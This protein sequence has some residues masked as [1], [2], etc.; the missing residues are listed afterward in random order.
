[1]DE[2]ELMV[3]Q[4]RQGMGGPVFAWEPTVDLVIGQ[5]GKEPKN[6]LKTGV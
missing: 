5:H 3:G 4:P 6:N 2:K 1:M